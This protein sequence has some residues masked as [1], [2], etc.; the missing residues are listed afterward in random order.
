ME[1]FD[2]GPTPFPQTAKEAVSGYPGEAPV[3]LEIYLRVNGSWRHFYGQYLQGS[4]FIAPGSNRTALE[5]VEHGI[6]LDEA[7]RILADQTYEEFA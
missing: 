7:V 2:P 4:L 1:G 5:P 3:D 6:K